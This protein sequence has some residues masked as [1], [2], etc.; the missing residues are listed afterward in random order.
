MD[1]RQL[2]DAIPGY[3]E[4][5]LSPET[6]SAADAH[7]RTCTRCRT[8]MSLLQ[9]EVPDLPPTE[10]DT[11]VREVLSRTSGASCRR[12]EAQLDTF[13]DGTLPG[14]DA[15][16]LA[17]HLTHCPACRS[18]METLFTLRIPLREMGSIDPGPMFVRNV[19][20]A[21]VRRSPAQGARLA[22]LREGWRRL[23]WR[24][25]IAFEGAYV[26]TL[27]MIVIFGTPISPLRDLP[28]NTL[29]LARSD[30]PRLTELLS[31]PMAALHN[32]VR[33][34]GEILWRE[35]GG[36]WVGGVRR[37][38]ETLTSRVHAVGKAT[39]EL[40][41]DGEALREAVFAGDFGRTG[42]QLRRVRADVKQIWGALFGGR[43]AK[44]AEPASDDPGRR[45]ISEEAPDERSGAMDTGAHDDIIV[46]P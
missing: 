8:L 42:L 45:E 35:T 17:G 37:R 32:A 24:P 16:L 26:A 6:L 2:T 31:P 10:D 38:S 14:E 5:A 11:F 21:T 41:E 28:S 3:L 46:A 36:N 4:G 22:R 43:S 1:C 9:S 27:I 34:T 18:L 30:P 20:R 15:T 39:A 33:R 40:R 19:L 44:A 23:L 25:R 29:S 13:L 12:A 7:L